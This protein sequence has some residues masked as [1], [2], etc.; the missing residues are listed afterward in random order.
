VNKFGLNDDDEM[1]DK[2]QGQSLSEKLASFP[3]V[4]PRMPIDLVAVDAAAAPHGFVSREAIVPL[5]FEE[6]KRRRRATAPQPT[7]HLAV[8]LVQTEYDR[9]VAYA[10]RHELTYHDAI[11]RLLDLT[12]E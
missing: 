10:D 2:P 11:S 1:Q 9:F 8:R 7:R 4:A 6:R 5:G 12:S 3:P